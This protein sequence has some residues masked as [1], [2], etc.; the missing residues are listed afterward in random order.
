MCFLKAIYTIRSWHSNS[1]NIDQE[2]NIYQHFEA[3]DDKVQMSTPA[4]RLQCCV[5]V[6]FSEYIKYMVHPKPFIHD[7]PSD[8]LQRLWNHFGLFPGIKS[9]RN[10]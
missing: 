7:G 10:I 2:L 4:G 9:H 6:P 1:Y 3:D 5:Q 8:S